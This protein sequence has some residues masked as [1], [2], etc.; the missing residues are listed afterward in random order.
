[1]SGAASR[2]PPLW[3]WGAWPLGSNSPENWTWAKLLETHRR[4]WFSFSG[5]LEPRGTQAGPYPAWYLIPG[6][7]L[8]MWFVTFTCTYTALWGGRKW[9]AIF[10]GGGP[11][12][13]EG[14]LWVSLWLPDP[15]R[16]L[17]LECLPGPLTPEN[18]HKVD[19]V[20]SC[21]DSEWMLG[22]LRTVALPVSWALD[23]QGRSPEFWLMGSTLPSIV[24]PHNVQGHVGSC[25]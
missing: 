23:G 12:P 3:T 6:Q 7:W 22:E 25:G 19:A 24:W 18:W 2:A 9:L 5:E 4:P 1:M 17:P 13:G 14:L 11:Y 20:T 8:W 21:P 16:Q 10:R 15:F